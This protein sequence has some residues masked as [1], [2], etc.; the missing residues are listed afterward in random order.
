MN[1]YPQPYKQLEHQSGSQFKQLEFSS[2]SKLL[3]KKNSFKWK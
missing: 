2:K 3:I 1:V